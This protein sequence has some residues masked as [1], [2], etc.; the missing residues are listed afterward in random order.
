MGVLAGLP[1]TCYLAANTMA[2]TKGANISR[3]VLKQA[4][5]AKEKILQNLGKSDKTTDE[6]FEEHLMNFNTQQVNSTRLSLPRRKC[7]TQRQPRFTQSWK[8]WWTNLQRKLN[9]ALCQGKRSQTLFQ[10][11][12][13]AATATSATTSYQPT[14]TTHL[15]HQKAP[16]R[17]TCLLECSTK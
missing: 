8:V 1:T 16:P 13:T 14:A 10:S 7:S 5:R 11:R 2:D 12:T 3:M 17:T 4:G 9:E 15:P 6:I